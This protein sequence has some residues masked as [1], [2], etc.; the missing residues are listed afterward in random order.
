MSKLYYWDTSAL[1]SLVFQE[2]SSKNIR[3]FVEKEKSLPAYTSF[4]TTIEMESALHQR[5]AAGSL[6]SELTEIRLQMKELQEGLALIWP[7]SELLLVS[8][9]K[10]MEFNLRPGDALQ[11]ASSIALTGQGAAVCFV[12]LDERLNNSAKASHIQCAF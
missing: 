8:C 9:K 2:S 11:L 4:F 5:V 7:S 12:C 6:V 10:V 3:S 1:L